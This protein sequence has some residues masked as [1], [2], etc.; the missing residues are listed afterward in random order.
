MEV[1]I[2]PDARRGQQLAAQYLASQVRKKPDC[3]LG[4]ATGNTML[5]VYSDLADRKLDFSRVTSFNLDEYVGLEE[6]D[7][8]SYHYYMQEHLFAKIN[9][10]PSRCHV[11]DGM[12]RDLNGACRAYEASIVAAGGIDL[13]LLGI[14]EDG[15]IA[16]NEPTSSLASR[17]RLKTL[18]PITLAANRLP[19][20]TDPPEHVLTMGVGTIME[21]RHCLLL[22]F[23]KRKA[24]IVVR[25]IEGPLTSMVPASAL[26]MHARTTVVLDEESARF[27]ALR[28]YYRYVYENKPQWQSVEG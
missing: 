16:F 15:H 2:V 26:Q 18:S 11:P 23:G 22:A 27:L 6:D 21:A 7:P 3:V 17:T 13:Q 28:D 5:G 9:I 19:E 20:G 25:F 8:N 14:G 24:Q 1:I 12:A 10:D 4:L